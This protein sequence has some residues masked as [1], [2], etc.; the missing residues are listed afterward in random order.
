MY[1][2]RL[3]YEL[4]ALVTEMLSNYRIEG[5]NSSA[6]YVDRV[7]SLHDVYVDYIYPMGILLTVMEIFGF[8]VDVEQLKQVQIAAE[9]ER[10][11]LESSFQ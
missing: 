8:K 3:T 11:T 4:W 6:T 10:V 5:T 9:Q 7:Q 2:A 1:D